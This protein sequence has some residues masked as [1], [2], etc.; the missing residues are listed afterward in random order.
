MYCDTLFF[1]YPMDFVAKQIQK[2]AYFLFMK[3]YHKNK[4]SKKKGVFLYHFILKRC[5]EI[6]MINIQDK[7]FQ[8]FNKLQKTL[9]MSWRGA[10]TVMALDRC[11]SSATTRQ[12]GVTWGRRLVEIVG[13]VLKTGKREKR[14]K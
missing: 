6:E 8:Y 7:Y 14:Q 9:R 12:I 3:A 10:L 13:Q 11:S 4:Y 1:E 5:I 2:K